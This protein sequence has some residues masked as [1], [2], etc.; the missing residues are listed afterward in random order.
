MLTLYFSPGSSS[1]AVHIALHEVG[2]EFERRLVSLARKEQFAPEYLALNPEGKVPTLMIDGRILTEVA[3]IL[4]YLAKRFPGGGVV[5]GC[6]A[7]SRGAGGLVDVVHRLD[8]PSGAPHRRRALAGGVRHRRAEV[9][10]AGVGGRALF[11]RRHPSVSPVLAFCRLAETRARR[12]PRAHP[13]IT[14]E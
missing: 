9:G 11:D 1:M 2:V 4:Y 8:D 14:S 7:R 10:G 3:A 12:I 13:P 5:A 6:R